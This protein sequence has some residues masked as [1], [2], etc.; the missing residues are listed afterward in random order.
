MPWAESLSDQKSLRLIPK[1]ERYPRLGIGVVTDE[2]E[3]ESAHQRCGLLGGAVNLVEDA[4]IREELLLGL[5][6]AAKH[7][8]DGE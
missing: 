3:D 8:V 7:F 6:P 1:S 5:V 4:A 2:Y